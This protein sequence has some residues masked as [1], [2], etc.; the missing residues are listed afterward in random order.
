VRADCVT[1]PE[2]TSSA[3]AGEF[4]R[5]HE[6][7]AIFEMRVAVSLDLSGVCVPIPTVCH[8]A[9]YSLLP[10]EVGNSPRI[11][12]PIV[13]AAPA[14]AVIEDPGASTRFREW[15]L[16]DILNC[17]LGDV[18]SRRSPKSTEGDRSVPAFLMPFRDRGRRKNGT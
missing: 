6:S 8:P 13:A 2:I 4:I 12:V 7:E 15:H 1:T 3:G 18:L 5:T 9:E 10:M 11:V 16:P 17:H 14:V